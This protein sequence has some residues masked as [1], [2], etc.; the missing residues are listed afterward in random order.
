MRYVV[1]SFLFVFVSIFNVFSQFAVVVDKDRYVNV[2]D[3]EKRIIGQLAEGE[4]VWCFDTNDKWTHVAYAVN[5]KEREGMIHSSRLYNV[6]HYTEIPVLRESEDEILLSSDFIHITLTKGLFN[7]K[8]NR[9]TRDPKQGDAIVMIN[10][11]YCWGTDGQV[12][13]YQYNKISVTLKD[14]IIN[15]PSLAFEDLF[16]PSLFSAEAYYNIKDDI[17]Y[18]TTMNGDGAG[19][20][21]VLWVVEK[22]VYK[23]RYVYFGF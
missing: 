18:V 14:T 19:G 2:R 15:F 16:N 22:G 9:L 6:S 4:V 10:N 23:K 17:L 3:S 20:Y 12:P 11:K 5:G 21:V 1:L 8:E 7:P 13:S